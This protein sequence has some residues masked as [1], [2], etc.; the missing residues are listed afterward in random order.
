MKYIDNKLVD[1][2][3][4]GGITFLNFNVSSIY[5]SRYA[6]VKFYIKNQTSKYIKILNYNK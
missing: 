4:E 6:F 2:L 3:Y 5:A 1:K